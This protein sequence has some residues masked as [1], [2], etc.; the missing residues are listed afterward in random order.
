[1]NEQNKDTVTEV[2]V[3]NQNNNS[4]GETK[5][6]KFSTVMLILLFIFLFGYVMFMPEI[7]DYIS[8]FN[9]E[10]G[11]SQIELDAIEEEKK[12]QQAEQNKKPVKPEVIETKELVCTLTNPLNG[13]YTLVEVQKLYYDNNNQVLNSSYSYQYKFNSFDE[14]YNSLK[15]KCNQDSLKYITHPGYTMACSYDD[16][17]IEIS[18]EFDL[19]IFE[20]IVDGTTN[21]QANATYKENINTIKNTLISKGYTCQ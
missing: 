14:Y 1:M 6:S 21:I 5:S 4:V 9:K 7:N 8:S 19:E 18:H 13:N 10:E 2:V 20:P 3:D 11:L 17:N 12:Q 15:N 16:I